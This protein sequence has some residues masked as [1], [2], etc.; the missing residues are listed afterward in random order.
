MLCR[1]AHNTVESSNPLL[2][3]L[4]RVWLA[5]TVHLP[6]TLER[7]LLPRL[8][9]HPVFEA[10]SPAQLAVISALWVGD[11]NSTVSSTAQLVGAGPAALNNTVGS[12][13]TP[14]GF[15]S[16]SKSAALQHSASSGHSEL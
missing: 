9:R 8:V 4:A 14:C 3:P 1:Q 2:R 5:V 11:G 12:L 15:V 13:A 10:A 6:Y 7:M 16:A